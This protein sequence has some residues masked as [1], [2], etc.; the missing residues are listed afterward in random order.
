M[1]HLLPILCSLVVLCLIVLP[2]SAQENPH[3]VMERDCENCHTMES[4]KDVHFDHASTGFVMEGKHRGL[5]CTACHTLKDFSKVRRNCVSCHQDIHEAKLGADCERCHTPGGW[6]VLDPVEIHMNTE[7][8]IMGAHALVDCQSCH[9]GLP[10]GDLSFPSTR[11][12]ACHQQLYLEVPNPNHVAAGFP[13]DCDNC[14]QMD[15]WRPALLPDH[16][17]FFPIYSGNHDRVWDNCATCHTVPD[18]FQEFTCIACHEH[19][20]TDMD[21]AHNGLPGYAY[22]SPDCY[23]CHPTG[24]AGEFA[25]HDAQFFPIF[26]G[27]HQG[28]WDNC[29]TCH[30]V[31]TDRKVFDC[32]GCHDHDQTPTDDAHAG[33]TDYAY[34]SPAC[35]DCHPTGEAGD[36]LAHDAQYFPVYSGTHQGSWDNCSTCHTVPGDRSQFDCL[37]CHEHDQTL[38]DD[39]HTG[40]TDYAYTS[41]DCY[42]CHPT[43]EAGD[44]LAHDAQYFPIYSGRHQ[45]AWADCATCHT[46]PGDRS[47]FDCLT[48]HEHEQTAMDG[49]HTGIPDYAYN[50]ADCYSCHPT[51]EAG[52][53][54][55]HDAQYFPIYSGN[56]QST[57]ASCATCH[58]VPTD[59]TQ[60]DCLACHEHEQAATD[61]LH[62]GIP[63]YN[64]ASTACF[65]CHPT[66]EKGQ[67]TDHDAL[68][69]P[70][71]SGTHN[72]RWND[73]SICH[74]TALDRSVFSCIECHDHNQTLM[75]AHHLGEV[76][77][78]SYS[79]TSC[80]DCHPD[81]QSGD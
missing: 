54:L 26:S 42:S 28:T 52:E 29:S 7:F 2:L 19:N 46:T 17:M 30:T 61:G 16:D 81:G 18:N 23:M 3:E 70:I 60:F 34:N 25:D 39:V 77:G 56:H 67:F 27:R 11:C 6:T 32:L 13:T 65:A 48:C 22:S 73:C 69:F 58:D 21:A 38:M 4:F 80:Y 55:A 64:Y 37:T 44:F 8:P 74:T 75:D 14:H 24:E 76:S 53:F 72:N 36:F 51:G 41:A 59:R 35:Y 5:D 31:P 63:D 20:Q 33:I 78:Y 12:V 43:G 66:G 45:G 9:T 15:R 79:A 62:S 49:A 57:W 50:S 10:K 47:Q 40:I 1:K 68:F 71:F